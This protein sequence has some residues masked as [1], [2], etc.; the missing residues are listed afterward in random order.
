MNKKLLITAISIALMGSASMVINP[1]YADPKNPTAIE[2]SCKN[3]A[4]KK[5]WCQSQEQP[6]PSQDQN[7]TD[8]STPNQDQNTIS[9]DTNNSESS[10]TGS[11]EE[12]ITTNNTTGEDNTVTDSNSIELEDTA[13]PSTEELFTQAN[14]AGIFVSV[15]ATIEWLVTNGISPETLTEEQRNELPIDWN[16]PQLPII[17]EQPITEESEIVPTEDEVVPTEDE[18]VPTEG[19]VVTDEV[20]PTED[21]VVPTE[22]EVVTDEVIP[23]EDKVVPTEGEVVTDEVVP[24]EDEVVPTE[25]EVVT[26]EVI[27]TEDEIVPTEDEAVPTE[28]EVVT[29]ESIEPT[30]VNESTFSPLVSEEAEQVIQ[31]QL[32]VVNDIVVVDEEG[33]ETSIPVEETKV[34]GEVLIPPAE[35]EGANAVINGELLNVKVEFGVAEATTADEEQEPVILTTV[36]GLEI[37]AP[38]IAPEAEVDTSNLITLQQ[39]ETGN[40]ILRIPNLKVGDLVVNVILKALTETLDIYQVEEVTIAPEKVFNNEDSTE[41]AAVE[42]TEPSDEEAT[43]EGTI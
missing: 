27:L 38:T 4:E 36:T 10:D 19:E 37:T 12:D 7:T 24:T 16:S 33:N 26:D 31:A 41:E 39:D 11:S 3:N 5:D 6:A 32:E 15:E 42:T 28:S 18:V 43:A 2:A 14:E 21:E 13:P 9:E 30:D 22:G 20:I 17:E 1:V 35:E 8:N 23:T 40:F 25:G 34:I 29:N